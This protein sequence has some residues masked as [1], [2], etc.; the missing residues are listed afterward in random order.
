MNFIVKF[1]M[2]ITYP[3]HSHIRPIALSFLHFFLP[4]P[5]LFHSTPPTNSHVPVW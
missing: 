3:D 5:F 1:P 2:Y 4:I